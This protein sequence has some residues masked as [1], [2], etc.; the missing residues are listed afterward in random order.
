MPPLKN[1]MPWW[2]TLLAI[3]SVI[4]AG[5]SH[6]LT[7]GY[8]TKTELATVTGEVKVLSAQQ[9]NSEKRLDQIQ[10]T[11]AATDVKVTDIHKILID[12]KGH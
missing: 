7:M 10:A 3:I 8:A 2:Q 12:W 5:A 4:G 9:V 11:T 1:S 6:Y